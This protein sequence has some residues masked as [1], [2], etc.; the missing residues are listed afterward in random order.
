MGWERRGKKC[1][2]YRSKWV[3]GRVVKEYLGDG[4]AALEAAR[5]DAEAASQRAERTFEQV[6]LAAELAALEALFD[7]MDAECDAQVIPAMAAK[8]YHKYRGV[9]RKKRKPKE[10]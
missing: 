4:P 5:Q 2:Y 10:G 9:W 8:G 6:K 1:Y 7:A 3:N